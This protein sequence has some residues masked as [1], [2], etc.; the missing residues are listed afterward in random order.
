MLTRGF[1]VLAMY[2]DELRLRRQ[3]QAP[4]CVSVIRLPDYLD[5]LG[6]RVEASLR[7]EPGSANT[8]APVA[9]QPMADIKN[10]NGVSANMLQSLS[11]STEHSLETAATGNS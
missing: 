1:I 4:N 6:G 7:I 5:Q 8:D 3:D 11:E 2:I 10:L 9:R